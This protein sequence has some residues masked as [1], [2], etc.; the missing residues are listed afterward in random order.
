MRPEKAARKARRTRTTSAMENG[1][2][3]TTPEKVHQICDMGFTPSTTKMALRQN[4]GDVASTL[5]WLIA[6]GAANEDE[7][8]PPKSS[9]SKKKK[10]AKEDSAPLPANEAPHCDLPSDRKRDRGGYSNTSDAEIAVTTEAVSIPAVGSTTAPSKS[11]KVSVV[12]PRQNPQ[13]SPSR[14]AVSGSTS[15]PTKRNL[16]AP[17]SKAKRRKT[18]LDQPEPSIDEL[19]KEKKKRGRPKKELNPTESASEGQAENQETKPND[20]NFAQDEVETKTMAA[21]QP[22]T[23]MEESSREAIPSYSGQPTTSRPTEMQPAPTVE[24]INNGP[25][26]SPRNPSNSAKAIETTQPR[27]KTPYRVGLS[28]RAR[29]AP[30]LRTLK[31]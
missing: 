12:I 2:A 19:P 9:T 20:K 11:P 28:K 10:T 7:L 27:N 18:T 23:I 5:D 3:A 16:E 6:N 17:R 8:A 14:N 1:S 31:K 4:N 13:A 22:A 25:S 26:K 29:I 21:V 30:L 15:S 24:D